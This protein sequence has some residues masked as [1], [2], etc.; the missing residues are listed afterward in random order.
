MSAAEMNMHVLMKASPLTPLLAENGCHEEW[1][2]TSRGREPPVKY[3][4][5]SIGGPPTR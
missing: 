3:C 2:P 4:I 5:A 1:P